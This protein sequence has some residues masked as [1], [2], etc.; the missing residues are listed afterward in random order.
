MVHLSWIVH[1][2]GCTIGSVAELSYLTTMSALL[3]LG[4]KMYTIAVIP[5]D[6]KNVYLHPLSPFKKNLAHH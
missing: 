2:V 1:S 5:T 4:L 3:S 6:Y